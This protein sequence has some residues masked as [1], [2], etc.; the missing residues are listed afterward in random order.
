MGTPPL[1]PA[2]PIPSPAAAISAVSSSYSVSFFG[3]NYGRDNCDNGD[4][5]EKGDEVVLCLLPASDVGS[6]VENFSRR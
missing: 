5:S 2:S 6:V 3:S 1:T 4:L